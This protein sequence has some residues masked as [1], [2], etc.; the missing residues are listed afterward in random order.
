[1]LMQVAVYIICPLL[2]LTVF[3]TVNYCKV[4]FCKCQLLSTFPIT[5]SIYGSRICIPGFSYKQTPSEPP[6]DLQ[7]CDSND[8][9]LLYHDPDLVNQD[10]DPCDGI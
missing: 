1:M 7:D 8:E 4:G 5:S 6:G 10:L 3:G 2:V 9:M